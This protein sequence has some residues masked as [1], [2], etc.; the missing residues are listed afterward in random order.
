MNRRHSTHQRWRSSCLLRRR[1]VPLGRR[2]SRVIRALRTLLLIWALALVRTLLRTTRP[3][4]RRRSRT[5]RN[6]WHLQELFVR[7]RPINRRAVTLS[8][9]LTELWRPTLPFRRRELVLPAP[10]TRR[11]WSRSRKL[12]KL[13]RRVEHDRARN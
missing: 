9:C 8:Y 12:Q 13:R 11:K 7:V 6:P 2:S 4:T 3:T 1:R 10:M 5:R